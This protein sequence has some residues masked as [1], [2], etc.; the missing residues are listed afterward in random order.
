MAR[1]RSQRP[2]VAQCS[3]RTLADGLLTIERIFPIPR[4]WHHSVPRASRAM[5]RSARIS[6]ISVDGCNS[7]PG[8]ARASVFV[9]SPDDMEP[10]VPHLSGT[11]QVINSVND[12]PFVARIAAVAR[13]GNKRTQAPCDHRSASAI[14][15]TRA[16]ARAK[17]IAITT[18]RPSK[19]SMA[20]AQCSAH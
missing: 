6:S 1:P 16:T 10:I 19:I 9:P 2:H 3:A 4:F 15:I 14:S 18:H 7:S 5:C 20:R 11:R 13:Q 12:E 17:G 8:S